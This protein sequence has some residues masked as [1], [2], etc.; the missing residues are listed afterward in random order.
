MKTFGEQKNCALDRFKPYQR[1]KLSHRG[2]K[3]MK[4]N[5]S[6]ANKQNAPT[7]VGSGD[8]LDHRYD[9]CKTGKDFA[10]RAIELDAM[11][12][13]DL[14]AEQIKYESWGISQLIQAG[15][16]PRRAAREFYDHGLA[17]V[18]WSNVES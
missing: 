8:L 11:M 10:M 17:R 16:P 7:T 12:H 18:R 9:G 4:N 1:N 3:S 5:K 13:R 6:E 2:L 15:L 14:D